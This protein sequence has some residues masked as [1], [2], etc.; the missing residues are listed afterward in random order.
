[1]IDVEAFLD[2]YEALCSKHGLFVEGCGCCD[3]P[4]LETVGDLS[5]HIAHLRAEA[6]EGL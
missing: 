5:D 2:E 3:S 1:M 4:Y 6:A